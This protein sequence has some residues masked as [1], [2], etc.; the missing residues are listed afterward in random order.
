MSLLF[1]AV[2][3]SGKAIETFAA[4]KVQQKFDLCKSFAKKVALRMGYTRI[5]APMPAKL[6]ETKERLTVTLPVEAEGKRAL[7]KTR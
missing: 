1:Y 7:V 4:A 5:E 2:G 3:I 6:T